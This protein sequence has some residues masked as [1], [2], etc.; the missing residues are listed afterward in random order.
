[1]EGKATKATRFGGTPDQKTGDD[2]GIQ[3]SFTLERIKKTH[4]FNH[5]WGK[6]KG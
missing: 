5:R 6:A 3:S 1:M 2:F 4:R